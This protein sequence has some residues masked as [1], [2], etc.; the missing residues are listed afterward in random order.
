M[1]NDGSCRREVSNESKIE[2]RE[3]TEREGVVLKI[4]KKKIK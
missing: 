3:E 1:K 4:K 2:G